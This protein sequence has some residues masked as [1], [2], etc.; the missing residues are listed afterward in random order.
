GIGFS[1]LS[2]VRAKRKWG[3]LTS[4]T[5]II[6]LA[7]LLLNVLGFVLIWAIESNNPDTLGDLPVHAQALGAWLQSVASRTAGFESF[8]LSQVRDGTTM[9]LM[10]LMFVGGGSLSTASGIKVGTFVVLLAAAWSYIRGQREI[11]L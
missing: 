4:Y 9:I 3:L 6:L 5:R 1:V 10:L 2:D 7:T 11:V 8:D